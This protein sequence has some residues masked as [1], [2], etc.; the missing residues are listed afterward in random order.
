MM[1]QVSDGAGA[2]LAAILARNRRGGAHVLRIA[3][4]ADG[5]TIEVASAGAGDE[6]VQYDGRALLAIEGAVARAMAGRCI[7]LVDTSN[8]PR[9]T[10]TKLGEE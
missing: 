7:D 1:V 3:A 6:V 2:Y 8:G 4:A 9:L 10:L 5:L